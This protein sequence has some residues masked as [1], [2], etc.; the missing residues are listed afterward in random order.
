MFLRQIG[1][2]EDPGCNL[3]VGGS[4]YHRDRQLGAS[5]WFSKH[6]D[7][8]PGHPQ[9]PGVT[10]YTNGSKWRKGNFLSGIEQVPEHHP[11]RTPLDAL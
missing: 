5:C 11:S 10:M 7:P 6:M 1:S 8:H 3:P 9:T 2:Q 4:W